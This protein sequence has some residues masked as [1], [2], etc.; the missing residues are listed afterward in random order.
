MTPYRT[1]AAAWTSCRREAPAAVRVVRP[2]D[3]AV[4]DLT[5]MWA[6]TAVHPPAR[7]LGRPGHHRRTG[8]PTRRAAGLA[9]A[10]SPR[11]RR[12]SGGSRGICA[13]ATT[14]RAFEA[15]D[16][17][18]RRA[19]RVVLRPR[20]AQPRVPDRRAPAAQPPPAGDLDP[21][22]PRQ[23]PWVAFGRG[24][25]RRQRARDGRRRRRRRPC[26][27]TPTRSPGWPPSPPPCAPWPT[28]DGAEVEVSLAGAIA[29]LLPT[30]GRPLGD[31]PIR[32]AIAQLAPPGPVLV[33][34]R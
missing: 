25:P 21:R 1:T 6:G 20:P 8:R 28:A 3:V 29:P 12:G 19:G 9:S 4:L 30:A 31:A 7:R 14:G 17:P 11:S 16:P 33:R 5:A 23:S 34:E 18:G 15:G 24:R 27:P 26:S 10:S 13:N 2:A 32:D 22:V